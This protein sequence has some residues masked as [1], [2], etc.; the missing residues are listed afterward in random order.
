[1]PRLLELQ[2]QGPAGD[3]VPLQP[4]RPE[5]IGQDHCVSLLRIEHMRDEDDEVLLVWSKV[6]RA[7]NL[8]LRKR[9]LERAARCRLCLD[10]ES[11]VAAL[12]K[13]VVAQAVAAQAV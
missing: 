13:E 6:L 11:R 5:R 10:K 2:P 12:D 4:S 3:A 7:A 1:V 8:R 9:E